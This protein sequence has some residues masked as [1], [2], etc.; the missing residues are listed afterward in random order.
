[1]ALPTA[2]IFFIEPR[3][4]KQEKNYLKIHTM[5]S[6]QYGEENWAMIIC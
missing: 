6:D 4:K 2:G 3:N 5:T 1:M